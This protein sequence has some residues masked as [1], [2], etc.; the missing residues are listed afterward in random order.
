MGRVYG[1]LCGMKFQFRIS[2]GSQLQHHNRVENAA[3]RAWLNPRW[4]TRFTRLHTNN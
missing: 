3:I 1:L 2:Y 4:W